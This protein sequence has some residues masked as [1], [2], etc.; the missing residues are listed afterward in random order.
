M[1]LFQIDQEKCNRDGFCVKACPAQVIVM[2]D[3]ESFPS[4]TDDAEEF[5]INC[6]H[7]LA[8]CPRGALTLSAMPLEECPPLRKDILPGPEAMEHMLKARRSIRQYKSTLLPRDLLEDLIDTARFAPTGSN[9]QEVHWTV[10]QD[11]AETRRLSAMVVDSMRQ[12]L[13]GIDDAALARR[14][15]RVIAAW[16]D[17]KDR[18][19]RGAP[20]L[21]I[22]HSPSHLPFAEADCVIALT[23][24]ELYAWS[25]GLGTCWGG[26]FTGAANSYP[27]LTEALRMPEGHRCYGAVMVGYPQYGYERIVQRNAPMITWR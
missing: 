18:I 8:V 11:K 22:V 17:G 25:I 2:A 27:P 12:N 21:I 4:P 6:G 26:Y 5:C 15:R 13:P 23:Y 14:V 10:Y 9:K 1:S 3:R 7:C 20:N 16:D 24:L 19:L